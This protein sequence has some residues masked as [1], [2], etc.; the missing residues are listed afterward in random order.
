MSESLAQTVALYAAGLTAF[1][2]VTAVRGRGLGRVHAAGA[3][4]L[5]AGA[6][7]DGLIAT[8]A[9]ATG[10]RPAEPVPFSAY[11]LLSVLAVPVGWRYA[12]AAGRGWDAAALA[13][14]TAA[15]GVICVRLGRTWG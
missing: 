13:L 2:L 9:V 5:G 15:L 1:S 6:A 14:A 11:L 7:L 8:A 10:A 12:R 3:V 4:V